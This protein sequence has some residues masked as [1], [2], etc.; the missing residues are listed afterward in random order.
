[1]WAG[2]YISLPRAA[3]GSQA[4]QQDVNVEKCSITDLTFLSAAG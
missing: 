1:M 4:G 3:L 2:R